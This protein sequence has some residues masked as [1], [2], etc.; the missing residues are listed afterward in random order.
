[1]EFFRIAG[2][3]VLGLAF[4]GFFIFLIQLS[5]G[6]GITIVTMLS[7]LLVLVLGAAVSLKYIFAKK[8]V[9]SRD[10]NSE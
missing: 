10:D 2:W 6:S 9:G 7:L 4:G 5:W 3:I 8:Q 1:M